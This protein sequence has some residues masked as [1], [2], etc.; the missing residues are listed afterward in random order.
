MRR[1][2]FIAGLGSVAAWPVAGRAQKATTPVIGYLSG[3]TAVD[4]AGV[5]ADFRRGLAETGHIEG[6]NVVIE[7]RWLE[8]RYDR[9]PSMLA[10]LVERRVAVIAIPNTTAAVLAAKAA[11]RTIP[12]VFNVGGDPIAMGVVESLSRPGGNL[13]GTATLQVAVIAKRLELLHEVARAATTVAFLRNPTNPVFAE[14]ETEEVQGATR[15]LGVRLLLLNASNRDQITMAFESIARE[16]P[17]A[18]AVSADLFFLN[19]RDQIVALAA[20]HGVP[21]IYGFHEQATA[22]GLMSYGF[23]FVET[24]RLTGV[25]TGRVLNGERPADL[26]VQQVTNIRLVINLKTA[27]ALGLTIPETLLATADEVIQ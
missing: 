7:Y 25:Y 20:R 15:V 12:I 4:S 23:E 17:A 8:G 27:K 16:Q 5:L 1:R 9:I 14:S 13:T 10:D 19:E 26:P 21:A 3:R 11:T 2:Q 22:G 24:N 6:R 18:L